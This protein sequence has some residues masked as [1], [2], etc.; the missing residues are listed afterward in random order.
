M[1]GSMGYER[2]WKF[3]VDRYD[4]PDPDSSVESRS[5]VPY[6]P[7][8]SGNA[9]FRDRSVSSV[10]KFYG[11]FYFDKADPMLYSVFRTG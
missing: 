3:F 7:C 9:D 4:S 5:T 8:E 2:Q 6:K 10:A 11:H 1:S